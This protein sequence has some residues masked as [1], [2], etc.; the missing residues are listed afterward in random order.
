MNGLESFGSWVKVNRRA[1]GL[2]QDEFARMVYCASITLRKIEANR[3]RPSRELAYS[4]V[5]GIGAAPEER[6]LLVRWA[7]ERGT[8]GGVPV[9]GH[10]VGA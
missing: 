7:R 2:T 8:T 6:D 5:D 4:I 3:L 9:M 10:F 1:L